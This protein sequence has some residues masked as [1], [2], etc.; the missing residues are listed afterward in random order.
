[1]LHFGGNLA[2]QLRGQEAYY[3]VVKNLGKCSLLLRGID[4]S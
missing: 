4:C 3:L 2:L 1:M